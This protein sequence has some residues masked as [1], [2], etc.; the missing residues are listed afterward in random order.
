MM[1]RENLQKYLK[2]KADKLGDAHYRVIIESKVGDEWTFEKM[3]RLTKRNAQ[4]M[5]HK[6]LVL[7][8]VCS[9]TVMDMVTYQ[10][11]IFRG[12]NWQN[13]KYQSD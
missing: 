7:N 12:M 13:R 5:L 8:E 6:K 9:V 11:K 10:M 1:K 2:K 3:N 4:D